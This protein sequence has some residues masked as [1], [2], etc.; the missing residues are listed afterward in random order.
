LSNPHYAGDAGFVLGLI[1]DD[2]VLERL[3][4][5]AEDGSPEL[6]EAAGEGTKRIQGEP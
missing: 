3:E 5:L 4:P 6:A 1:G 2:K